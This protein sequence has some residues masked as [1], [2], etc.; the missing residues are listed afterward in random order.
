KKN[1]HRRGKPR[2]GAQQGRLRRNVG[3]VVMN[4]EG[5][6]LAGLRSHANGDKAWQLPQGGIE[7]RERP[8]TA[9]YRELR[10]ETGLT[11]DDVQLVRELPQWTTYVLPKEWTQGRRFVG[12]RQKWFL[13]SFK[14]TGLP[15]VGKAKDFEFEALDWVSPDWLAA[16]VIE[17]RRPIYAAVFKGFAGELKLKD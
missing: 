15:D 14:G 2:P 3:I 4:A 16:H 1:R 7:G 17:F 9:A 13:F 5:K 6:V 12:Q 8:L 10:E 11:F